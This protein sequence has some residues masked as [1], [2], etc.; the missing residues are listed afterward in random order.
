MCLIRRQLKVERDNKEKSKKEATF[1]TNK[2]VYA[3]LHA[4][5]TPSAMR[6]DE[7]RDR[8]LAMPHS[9]L[10]LLT[11]APLCPHPLRA[12]NLSPS[13]QIVR[14]LFVPPFLP[15][16]RCHFLRLIRIMPVG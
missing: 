3:N 13:M 9:R 11:S 16:A 4:S 1:C 12:R 14:F 15:Y 10:G 8:R 2:A 6:F 7:G 5:F